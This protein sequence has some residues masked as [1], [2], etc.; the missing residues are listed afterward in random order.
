MVT[1]PDGRHYRKDCVSFYHAR[2]S[3]RE[4][5]IGSFRSLAAACRRC[6]VRVCSPPGGRILRAAVTRARGWIWAP[7]K[8]PVAIPRHEG[9]GHGAGGKY[10]IQAANLWVMPGGLS[11]TPTSIRSG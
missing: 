3:G 9:G 5:P 2:S 8:Q 6:E 7:T 4:R 1:A 11:F 10:Q